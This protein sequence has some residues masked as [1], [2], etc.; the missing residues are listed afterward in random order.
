MLK[1]FIFFI[2]SHVLWIRSVLAFNCQITLSLVRGSL[3]IFITELL[4]TCLLDE[5]RCLSVE[6][7]ILRRQKENF[8]SIFSLLLKSYCSVLSLSGVTALDIEDDNAWGS[9]HAKPDTFGGLSNSLLPIEH[10]KISAKDSIEKSAF[11][12]R[13]WTNDGYNLILFRM[14]S[15]CFFGKILKFLN[16]LIN[17]TNT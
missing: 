3:I 6:C 11:S 7:G 5:S 14:Q 10:L 4:S 16:S 15:M 9:L 12:W 13:L 8:V 17:M 2:R 1:G